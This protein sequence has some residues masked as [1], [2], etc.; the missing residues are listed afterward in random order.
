MSYVYGNDQATSSDE[1]FQNKLM[2]MVVP[3]IFL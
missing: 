2:Y 1:L 3:I